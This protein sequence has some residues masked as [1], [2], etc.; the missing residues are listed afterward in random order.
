MPYDYNSLED[1]LTDE[2]SVA[3]NLQMIRQIRYYLLLSEPDIT[4]IETLRK[5]E[6]KLFNLEEE[7]LKLDQTYSPLQLQWK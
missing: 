2:S 1:Y 7:L 6:L 4:S 5:V 3:E